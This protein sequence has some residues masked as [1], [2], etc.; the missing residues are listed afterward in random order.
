MKILQLSRFDGKYGAAIAARRLHEALLSAGEQCDFLVDQKRSD[1]PRTHVAYT[2]VAKLMARARLRLDFLP[3]QF[4][5]IQNY[6]EFSLNWVPSPLPRRI[7]D[8]GP[9]IVHLHWCLN[10]FAPTPTLARIGRPLIW[11][12]HDMWAFTGGCHYSAGCDRY[13]TECGACPVLKSTNENDVSRRLWRQ[14]SD[15]YPRIRNSLQVICPSRWLADLARN[16]PLLDGVPVHALPNPIDAKVFH[17]IPKK[18]ARRLLNL[19]PDGPLLLM[20]AASTSDRRKGFDLL[21][22]ALQ[23][24]AAMP[25]AQPLGLVTLGAKIEASAVASGKLKMWNLDFI[26]DEAPL[27]TL[28]NAIDLVAL[29]SREEN[30]S[31]TLAE[32]LCCGVPCLAF[33]IGG[34][35]DLIS[36]Q[37]NGY[38]AQANDTTDMAEGIRWILT[39]FNDDRREAV[40]EMAHAQVSYETVVPKFLEIYRSAL[41]RWATVTPA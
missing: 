37:I 9:D 25:D 36:H 5:P 28:Y 30:L 33:D 4:Y 31:N 41:A 2:G 20:G 39:H 16:A 11:T 21:D 27:A 35:G 22:E 38:L 19:P 17:P 23:R 34:N 6:S 1:F 7:D 13:Y 12:F 26:D 3:L 40:S 10:D 32:A 24:Y 18:E 15:I 29:P 8:F 14:K